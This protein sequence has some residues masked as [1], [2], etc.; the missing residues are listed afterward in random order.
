MYHIKF[1]EGQKMLQ[2][3][4]CSFD[5][6]NIHE[7]VFVSVNSPG[8]VESELQQEGRKNTHAVPQDFYNCIHPVF[9]QGHTVL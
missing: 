6:T 2:K 8:V 1:K 3:N 4:V 9:A 7:V 5:T